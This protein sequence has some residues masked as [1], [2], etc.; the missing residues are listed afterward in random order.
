M[1]DYILRPEILES[2]FYAWRATGNTKY[3]DNA[4]SAMQSFQKY[5][6]TTVAYTGTND[7][8]NVTATK[9]DDME[10]FW[11]AETLKYLYLTFDDPNHISLDDCESLCLLGIRAV[12]EMSL[13][14]PT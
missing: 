13:V 2:N 14:F 10:S 8:N 3:L 1:S 9:Y 5:L 6:P 12:A 11:F 7:V 4:V